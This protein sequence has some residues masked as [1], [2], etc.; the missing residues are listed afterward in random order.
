MTHY[1]TETITE[2]TGAFMTRVCVWWL[3]KHPVI[4][5]IPGAAVVLA[6]VHRPE[7]L[8]VALMAVFL[9]Y[10]FL[11]ANIYFKY[12]FLP[13]TRR[14]LS[15]KTVSLGDEGIE[16][17][18]LDVRENCQS[19]FTETEKS[20]KIPYSEVSG[21]SLSKNKVVIRLSAPAYASIAI[22]NDRWINENTGLQ[23]DSSEILRYFI[24]NGIEIA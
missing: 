1:R 11:L 23:A 14:L 15:P 10:P 16:L 24:E 4:L 12:G 3:K 19:R 6:F 2:P 5:L 17:S 22:E 13:E 9:I 20:L 8:I 21:V 7:W 18:I